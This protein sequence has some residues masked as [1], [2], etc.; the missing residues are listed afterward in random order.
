[1]EWVL[2]NRCHPSSRSDIS[3]PSLGQG[4]YM[5][6][7]VKIMALQGSQG[8][9]N[10]ATDPSRGRWVRSKVAKPLSRIGIDTLADVDGPAKMSAV[11]DR[12]RLSVADAFRMMNANQH[13]CTSTRNPL[14]LGRRRF[15]WAQP[16]SQAQREEKLQAL[17][18]SASH[19]S[20]GRKEPI[21]MVP[22]RVGLLFCSDSRCRREKGFT[23]EVWQSHCQDLPATTR[24]HGQSDLHSSPYRPPSPQPHSAHPPHCFPISIDTGIPFGLQGDHRKILRGI[25]AEAQQDEVWPDPAATIHCSMAGA[26]HRLR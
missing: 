7:T 22:S 14:P 4:S 21:C 13:K 10:L 5:T 16:S 2:C 11:V 24:T 18:H 9:L 17:C 6:K 19:Q 12:F 1:M 20:A 15:V 8:L 3:C 26:Q 25:L 23:R